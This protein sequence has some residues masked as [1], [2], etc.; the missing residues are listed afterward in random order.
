MREHALITLANLAD[1]GS[2]FRLATNASSAT[3][4]SD[5]CA[6]PLT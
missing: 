4:S 6:L 2:F 5:V 1:N 3:F